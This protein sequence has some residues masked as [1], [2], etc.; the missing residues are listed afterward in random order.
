MTKGIGRNSSKVHTLRDF[1]STC[2]QV[3]FPP[4]SYTTKQCLFIKE[5][6]HSSDSRSPL[7]Q[8]PLTSHQP[9]PAKV[10]EVKVEMIQR[11]IF[12]EVDGHPASRSTA[13]LRGRT[14]STPLYQGKT[15]G[16]DPRPRLRHHPLSSH[17]P[18]LMK[19]D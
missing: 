1:N 15:H 19:L 7:R 18:K 13:P 8:H 11:I 14:I 5:D 10:D 2:K 6:A 4:P 9:K 17:Q 12:S 3:S 16:S